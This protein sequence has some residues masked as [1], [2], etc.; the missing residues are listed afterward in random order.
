MLLLIGAFT[1]TL[2]A[3]TE[4]LASALTTDTAVLRGFGGLTAQLSGAFSALLVTVLALVFALPDRPMLQSMRN[5]GHFLDL[6]AS[7][8]S[9]IAGCV[10]LVVF[11]ALLSIV[12]DSL[13]PLF[14]NLTASISLPLSLLLL[15]VVLKFILTLIAI[16]LPI[17]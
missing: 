5:S 1:Y 2:L 6:C 16:A 12:N 9:G 4:I 15:Q 11:A 8:L 17:H 3:Q 13:I 10:V 14:L 7:M